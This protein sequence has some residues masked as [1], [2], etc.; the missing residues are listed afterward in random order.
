MKLNVPVQ[1][2]PQPMTNPV[3]EPSVPNPKADPLHDVREI[4][5]GI[6]HDSAQAPREYLDEIRIVLGAE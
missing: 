2:L 6:R 4:I 1:P 3:V 5:E